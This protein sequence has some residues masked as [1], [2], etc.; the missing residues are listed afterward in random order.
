MPKAT[1]VV[2]CVRLDIGLLLLY[3]RLQAVA[4]SAP[5]QG[6][7]RGSFWQ[8]WAFFYFKKFFYLKDVIVYSHGWLVGTPEG[9]L[10][11]SIEGWLLGPIRLAGG[12]Q[13]QVG[14]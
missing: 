5:P 11:N 7:T 4:D 10:K 13:C 14:P 9:W 8:W 1:G 12:P 6:L 3:I 2:A